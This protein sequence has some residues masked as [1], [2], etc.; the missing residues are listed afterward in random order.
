M[1]GRAPVVNPAMTDG[2]DAIR[3][4][5]VPVATPMSEDISVDTGAQVTVVPFEERTVFAAPIVVRPVPLGA[6]AT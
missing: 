1:A 3:D 5:L 6:L 4:K 2:T